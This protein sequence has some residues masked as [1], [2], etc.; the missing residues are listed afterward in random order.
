MGVQIFF[1]DCVFISFGTYDRFSFK[2]FKKLY[3][4]LHCDCTSQHLR[5]GS[6]AVQNVCK[7]ELIFPL[8][9]SIS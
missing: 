5:W 7:D 9:T 2:F 4:V 3:A 6:L 8:K 1:Q